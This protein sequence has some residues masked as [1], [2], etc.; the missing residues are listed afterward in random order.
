[1]GQVAPCLFNALAQDMQ[2]ALWMLVPCM[3]PASSGF[4]MQTTHLAASSLA[5][6]GNGGV[7]LD[8]A[9]GAAARAAVSAARNSSESISPAANRRRASG[10]DSAQIPGSTPAGAMSINRSMSSARSLGTGVTP[11]SSHS[12]LSSATRIPRALSTASSRC[13]AS[14][15]VRELGDASRCGRDRPRPWAP[16]SENTPA[17]AS[18]AAGAGTAA[19]RS[20]AFRGSDNL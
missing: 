11:N 17:G 13:R 19:G 7:A 6:G 10:P 15:A 5:E 8:L 1:M 9:L 4:S 20:T 3:K 16:P 18:A 12:A 2:H 14:G